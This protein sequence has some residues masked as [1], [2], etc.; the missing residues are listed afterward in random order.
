MQNYTDFSKMKI[1]GIIPA[2]LE[3]SRLS[4]KLL[5]KI[6][7]KSVLH[8]VYLQAKKSDVLAEVFIATDSVE[9]QEHA[10]RFG[11]KVILTST[12]ITSGTQRCKKAAEQIDFDFDAVVNIQ[13]DEPFISP[14]QISIVAEMLHNSDI[15]TLA[16]KIEDDNE[17]ENPNNVKV[18]FDE[19]FNALYFSRSVIPFIRNHDNHIPKTQQS[20]FYKHIGL[21]AYKREVLNKLGELPQNALEKTESLEQLRW[22]ANDFKISVG[23]TTTEA[24]GIDTAEDL[25]K[26]RKF[27]EPL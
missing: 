9:I 1:I 19:K 13:G 18:V 25:A 26:A 7:D 22:L 23:I 5:Q 17:L 27:I 2:R 20:D 15:A 3:S 11:A 4:K 16:K 14:K 24:I 21:Y 12:E 8:R 10:E 6:G